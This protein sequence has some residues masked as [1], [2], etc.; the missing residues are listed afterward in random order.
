MANDP[1]KPDISIVVAC[2]NEMPHLPESV[3]EIEDVLD[4]T[5]YSYE[6]IFIDDKSA[7]ATRES[8]EHICEGKKNFRYVFHEKN[9]GRGGTVR[10]GFAMAKGTYAGFLD[11]DLEVRAWYIPALIGYLEKGADV[12]CIERIEEWSWNPYLILRRIVSGGYKMLS[13]IML[14]MRTR[15]SEAGYK[16][17]KMATMADL[18]QKTTDKGWFWDTEIIMVAEA[19]RKKVQSVRGVFT[20]RPEKKST[21]RLMP[22]SVKHFRALMRFRKEHPEIV[23]ARNHA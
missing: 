5:R 23:H 16:F 4:R 9:V 22:D 1:E 17:F 10:E 3:K 8:I 11:I 18:I 6:L 19:A 15:D 21:V 2:Y 14:P 20:K 13:K 7:D 12:A